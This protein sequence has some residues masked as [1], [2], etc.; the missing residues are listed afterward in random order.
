MFSYGKRTFFTA[1]TDDIG[2]YFLGPIPGPA[3]IQVIALS[4]L[5]ADA[6]S[7]AETTVLSVPKSSTAALSDFIWGD[8]VKNSGGKPKFISSGHL[9]GIQFYAAVTQYTLFHTCNTW[10]VDALAAAGLPVSSD[11]VIF[12]G[13]VV[14]RA[15]AVREC[16]A[17]GHEPTAWAHH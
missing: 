13:Q 5:P 15:E 1:P 17:A 6:Y 9:G 10:A 3:A 8:I 4:V 16:Q 12:S 11:N 2:E 14:T 7:A